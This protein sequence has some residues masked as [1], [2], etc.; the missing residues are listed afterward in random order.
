MLTCIYCLVRCGHTAST[1]FHVKITFTGAV[2]L[3]DR[4]HY[5]HIF[6]GWF[7]QYTSGT[8]AEYDA[9]SAIGIVHYCRHLITANNYN[10]FI[11]AGFNEAGTCSERKKKARPCG[12]YIITKGVNCTNSSR[13]DVGSGRKSHICSYR[14]EDQKVYFLGIEV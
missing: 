9:G 13:N 10:F 14:R 4:I 11:H 1:S 5:P 2:A 12:A 7:Q 8:V 6:S 3:K